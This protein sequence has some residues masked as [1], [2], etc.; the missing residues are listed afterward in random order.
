MS[1]N[2]CFLSYGDS[3]ILASASVDQSNTVLSGSLWRSCIIVDIVLH[4]Q[5]EL[6]TDNHSYLRHHDRTAIALCTMS[7]KQLSQ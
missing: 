7:R 6:K 3:P 2:I 1:Y 4:Q 5:Q